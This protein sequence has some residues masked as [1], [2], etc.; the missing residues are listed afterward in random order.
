MIGS[1]AGK[2]F[3]L[4]M[5][6]VGT[7]LFVIVRIL[8]AIFFGKIKTRGGWRQQGIDQSFGFALK[9]KIVAFVFFLVPLTYVVLC[10]PAFPPLWFQYALLGEALMFVVLAA[11]FIFAARNVGKSE[12]QNLCGKKL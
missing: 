2:I 12:T 6:L 9:P 3:Y 10:F 1:I 7:S 5:F 4:K 8:N 11:I